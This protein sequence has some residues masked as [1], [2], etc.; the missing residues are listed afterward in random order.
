[1]DRIKLCRSRIDRDW[2]RYWY[3]SNW[4][5]SNGSYCSSTRSNWKN[6]NSDVIAAALIEG[7]GFAALF[8]A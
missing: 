1:M 5:K 2:C 3:R 6:P 4:W 8:A 7:I